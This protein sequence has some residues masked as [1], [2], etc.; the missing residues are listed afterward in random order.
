MTE[1]IPSEDKSKITVL[2]PA[3]HMIG[4]KRAAPAIHQYWLL[5]L[6]KDLSGIFSWGAGIEKIETAV[7]LRRLDGTFVRDAFGEE[8]YDRIADFLAKTSLIFQYPITGDQE[9]NITKLIYWNPTKLVMRDIA[10]PIGQLG[11][12]IVPNLK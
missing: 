8:P 3:V 2:I 9:R 7:E 10:V 12:Q 11:P 1:I 4:V 6:N 5:D